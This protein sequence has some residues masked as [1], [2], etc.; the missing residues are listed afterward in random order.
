LDLSDCPV[1]LFT[2]GGRASK[3]LVEFA[4]AAESR[5]SALL[6]GLA[7]KLVC[8]PKLIKGVASTP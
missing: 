6:L 3:K 1:L 4:I 8:D 5:A 7:R 2:A